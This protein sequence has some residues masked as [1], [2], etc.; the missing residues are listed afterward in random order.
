MYV[1]LGQI[2]NLFKGKRNV[3]TAINNSQCTAAR[4]ILELKRTKHS[5]KKREDTSV[6][7]CGF[8]V[9]LIGSCSLQVKS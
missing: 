6:K 8:Y 5:V 3:T 7:K 2:R 1:K 9:H 4:R